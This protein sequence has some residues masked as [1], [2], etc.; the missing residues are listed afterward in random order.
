MRRKKDSRNLRVLSLTL[1]FHQAG[2]SRPRARNLLREHCGIIGRLF[3]KASMMNAVYNWVWSL[4]DFPVFFELSAKPGTTI[5]PYMPIVDN[6]TVLSMRAS[7]RPL[8]FEIDGEISMP[9]FSVAK[10]PVVSNEHTASVFDVGNEKVEKIFKNKIKETSS[11]LDSSES[12]KNQECSC[13]LNDII[14][15]I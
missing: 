4:S 14:V 7:D 12:V 1:T 13:D 6:N 15:T 2:Q 5:F 3:N 9:G 8:P 10:Y 11:E